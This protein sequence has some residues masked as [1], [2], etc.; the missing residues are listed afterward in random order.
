[1]LQR[2]YSRN[3]RH[4]YML[5]DVVGVEFEP[6]F[7]DEIT[8]LDCQLPP[9]HVEKLP[10][11][12]VVISLVVEIEECV[13]VPTLDKLALYFFADVACI[14]IVCIA[15]G[16]AGM[17]GIVKVFGTDIDG[18]VRIDKVVDIVA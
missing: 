15:I 9:V 5:V 10:D 11:D 16:F 8:R 18:L 1:M 6:D 2:L 13:L 12:L 7:S 14:P 4:R 3:P 17:R